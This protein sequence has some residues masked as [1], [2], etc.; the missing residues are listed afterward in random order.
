M[1]TQ[2][3]DEII[4]AMEYCVSGTGCFECAYFGRGGRCMAALRADA[5]ELIKTL[6]A[7]YTA[8]LYDQATPHTKLVPVYHGKVLTEE[9][10]QEIEKR[11]KDET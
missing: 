1:M 9:E 4:R 7:L 2:P 6:D 11:A 8:H 5:L 3:K 10:A